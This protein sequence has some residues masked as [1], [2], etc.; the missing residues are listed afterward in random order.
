MKI[1]L[2]F[3]FAASLAVVLAATL[4]LSSCRAV[5]PPAGL[6]SPNYDY[7]I[8]L[9]G[10]GRTSRSMDDMATYLD[11]LNYSVI[12]I[13]YPS[14]LYPVDIL[15]RDYISSTVKEQCVDPNVRIHF[16]THSL[17]GILTRYYLKH[18]TNDHIGRV[19]MLSPPNKGSELPDSFSDVAGFSAIMGPTA[20]SLGTSSNS[21][22]NSLGPVTHE[23][24]VITGD[25][26]VNPFYSYIIPGKDDGKVSVERAKV[27]GM[28]D[29]IIVP[30]SHTF[31]MTDDSVLRQTAHFLRYGRF[32]VTNTPVQAEEQ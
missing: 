19:V 15:V 29:F 31:I 10:L 25:R 17:G 3:L 2:S 1:A 9:H 32:D 21:V 22:P 18:Y 4:F 11:S 14:R 23:V 8:L 30:N 7:V 24:G 12:N 26:T 28:K 13:D 27:D 5:S 20:V 16:V 6:I